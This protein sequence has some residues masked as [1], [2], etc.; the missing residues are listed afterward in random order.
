MV[1]NLLGHNVVTDIIANAY[2]AHTFGEG[3]QWNTFPQP[4]H[5]CRLNNFDLIDPGG[6][7]DDKGEAAQGLCVEPEQ[8]LISEKAVI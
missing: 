4:E 5:D 3:R 2:S 6:T 7:G 1:D 8:K